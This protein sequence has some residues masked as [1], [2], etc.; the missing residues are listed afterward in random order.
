M[1]IIAWINYVNLATAKSVERARE[2]GVRKVMG[3]FRIQLIQQFL[4]ESLFLN[5]IAVTTAI[6]FGFALTPW[7]SALTGRALGYELFQ[8]NYFWGVLALLIVSGALMSGLY[9]AFILSGF[10]PVEVLKGKFK[11]SGR[12]VWMR[13]GMVVTQFVASITLMVGTFTVYQQLTFM[14]SQSLGVNVNQTVVLHSPTVRD[15]TYRNKFDVFRQKIEG[16][17]DVVSI[18]ADRKSV[19]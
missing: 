11:N 12:G 1:V 13:K 7:F 9:P 16:Q 19:V 10:K 4:T 2:V 8:Q 15:S 6:G 18:S 14:R 3:G 5:V 17:S